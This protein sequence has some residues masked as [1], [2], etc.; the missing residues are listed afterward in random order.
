MGG[1]EDDLGV[2]SHLF[3]PRRRFDTGQCSGQSVVEHHDPWLRRS[4]CLKSLLGA[5]RHSSDGEAV[6]HREDSFDEELNVRVVLDDEDLHRSH[7]Q[8]P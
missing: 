7:P 8:L 3:E 1:E 4:R 5:G 2:R 6:I